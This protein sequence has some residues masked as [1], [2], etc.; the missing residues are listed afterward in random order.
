MRINLHI[1]WI[2][3]FGHTWLV[4]LDVSSESMLVG[5]VDYLSVDAVLVPVAIAASYFLWVVAFFLTP[6]LVSV[7][8]FDLR[9]YKN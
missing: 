9:M 3:R 5:D 6:L 8:I 1:G 4:R 2:L 7:V